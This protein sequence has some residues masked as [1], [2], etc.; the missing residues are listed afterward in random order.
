M[1]NEVPTFGLNASAE[2]VKESNGGHLILFA[3]EDEA[4]NSS[5]QT[6]ALLANNGGSLENLLPEINYSGDYKIWTLPAI[7]VMPILVTALYEWNMDDPDECHACP[8]HV[9]I[10]SYVYRKE[11]RR[12][13]KFDELLTPTKHLLYEKE[14]LEEEKANIL[15]GLH[16][17]FDAETARHLVINP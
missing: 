4:G 6:I 13:V 17:A 14:M 15:A 3:A 1:K 10:T 9:R 12:Y 16:K 8:H 11:E 2:E 7:S 5:Y